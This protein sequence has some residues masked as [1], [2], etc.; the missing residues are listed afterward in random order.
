ML[1]RARTEER[2]RALAVEL[3]GPPFPQP[4]RH[5]WSL[6]SE[7]A[8]GLDAGGFG[9]ATVTWQSLDAWSRLTGV[10]LDPREAVA[11]VRLGAVRAEVMD[12]SK[13]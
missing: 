2:Q 10:T 7:I 5:L 3:A 8:E 13:G 12:R 4:L 1:R 9:P 11:L 6:F